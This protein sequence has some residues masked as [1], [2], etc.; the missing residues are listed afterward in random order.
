VLGILVQQL[1]GEFDDRHH[2]PIGE[3]VVDRAVL[4]TRHHEPTPAQARQVV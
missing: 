3:A 2:P 4:A 1:A